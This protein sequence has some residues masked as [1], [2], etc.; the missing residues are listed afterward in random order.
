MLA[1]SMS[2][3]RGLLVIALG[4]I[5]DATPAQALAQ[6]RDAAQLSSDASSEQRVRIDSGTMT[7]VDGPHGTVAFLGI[8]YAAPPTGAWRWRPP[9]PPAPW[10]GIRAA[11]ALGPACP[12]ID[13]SQKIRRVVV[14]ALGADP[15][16]HPTA[17]P[18]GLGPTSEDC[19]S[20]NV[21]TPDLAAQTKRP[22]MVWLHGGS[23]TYGSGGEDATA[24]AADGTVVVTLNYRLGLLGFLAHP[25]LTEESPHHASGNYGLLDQI[26]A[27]RWVRRNIAAFGGDP[28]RVTLFGHSSGGDSVLQLLSSPQ[29]HGLFQRAIVQSGGLGESRPLAEVEAEG[30]EIAKSLGA[31]ASDPLRALRAERVERL[32]SVTPPSAGFGPTTDGWLLPQ[33]VPQALAEGHTGDVPLLVGATANEWAIFAL[34]SPPADDLEGYRDLLAEA[35]ASRLDRLLALYPAASDDEVPRAAIRYLTDRDFVCPARFVAEKRP[36]ST[37]LYRVSA[38]AAAAPA[39][40]RYGAVHGSDVR[41]LFDQEMGL[42]LGEAGRRAGDA[43]RRYWTQFAATGDPNTAGLPRWPAY[44]GTEPRHLEIGDSIR[45]L[46]DLD[47]GGC[48]VFDEPH[49]LA[50]PDRRSSTVPNRDDPGRDAG[51]P[52]SIV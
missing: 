28:D 14:T 50:P 23:Y 44:E 20:L 4:S 30:V 13:R 12:Q 42:P 35:G 46:T 31:P 17:G 5:F 1:G 49:D 22:V 8:P 51:A 10:D 11:D 2:K 9:R 33:T 32:L 26:A 24:L 47:R 39:A 45:A 36:A 29:A 15:D 25:E 19:L 48:D 37:W 18:P 41:L 21:W 40:A 52:S 6:L 43:M 3:R 38:P 7:G 34:H 16:A 27:L